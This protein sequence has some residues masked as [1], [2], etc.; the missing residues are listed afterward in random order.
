M[1]SNSYMNMNIGTRVIKFFVH[2]TGVSSAMKQ[3][4]PPAMYIIPLLTQNSGYEICWKISVIIF[5]NCGCTVV[6]ADCI[7]VQMS[8]CFQ[9]YTVLGLLIMHRCPL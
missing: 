4:W 7:F 9:C 1:Q 3:C 5:D 2:Q 8:N 6:E